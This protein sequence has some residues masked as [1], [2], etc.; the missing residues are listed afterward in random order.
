MKSAFVVLLAVT[1]VMSIVTVPNV[2]ATEDIALTTLADQAF[3]PI[4]STYE[5]PAP[6]ADDA[7]PDRIGGIYIR[8]RG[9]MVA[10]LTPDQ[11]VACSI[12]V[13]FKIPNIYIR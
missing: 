1:L 13:G 3:S 12:H 4:M 2:E 9:A 6:D 8:I 10:R 11:K 7:Q 5:A